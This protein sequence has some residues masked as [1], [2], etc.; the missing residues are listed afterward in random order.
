[1]MFLQRFITAIF[2][3]CL[4]GSMILNVSPSPALAASEAPQPPAIESAIDE[5]F[6]TM[7]DRFYAVK[8]VDDLKQE[9]DRQDL[10]LIDVRSRLEY[11]SGHI[12]GAK[13]IPLRQLSQNRDRIPTDKPVILYCSVGYRTAMGVMALRLLGYENVRGFPPSMEGWKAA[14]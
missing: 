3:L 4:A 11:L 2:G 10:V 6:D 13:N 12:D 1:M 14:Q 8:T 7:P 5:F 9:L